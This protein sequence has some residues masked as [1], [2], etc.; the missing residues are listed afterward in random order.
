[1]R[2]LASGGRI[3]GTLELAK[4]H[5]LH[6][7]TPRLEQGVAAGIVY[8]IKDIDPTNPG[9]Q[10]IQEI[11]RDN[12]NSY[13]AVLCYS[14]PSPSGDYKGLHPG[15]DKILI[16]NIVKKIPSVEKL[17]T[18]KSEAQSGFSSTA[19]ILSKINTSKISKVPFN[20]SYPKE[21]ESV[22]KTLCKF[23]DVFPDQKPS[24]W[25]PMSGSI[26]QIKSSQLE[27]QS[28]NRLTLSNS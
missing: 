12:K 15:N 20:L 11:Y 6:V 21:K 13:A 7:P 10:K 25:K 16:D 18:N 1:M 26:K 2:K 5:H 27:K 14:G 23:H 24:F 9:C 28:A 17:S 8:A 3:R 19:S 22:F 4:K